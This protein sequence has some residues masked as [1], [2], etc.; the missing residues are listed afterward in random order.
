M[1]RRVINIK[2]K[3]VVTFGGK[4][5]GGVECGRDASVSLPCL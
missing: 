5:G 3:M 4:V 1:Y 2:I